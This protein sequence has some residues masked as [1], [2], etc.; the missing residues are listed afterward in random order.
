MLPLCATKECK[1]MYTRS[2]WTCSDYT[3]WYEK[4]KNHCVYIVVRHNWHRKL[5]EVVRWLVAQNELIAKW[6]NRNK[7]SNQRD[8]F[9][10]SFSTSCCGLHVAFVVR[11]TVAFAYVQFT[12]D[13]TSQ[14]PRSRIA[15]SENKST[16]VRTYLFNLNGC[17]DIRPEII[18]SAL[19]HASM[20]NW[21]F[22][23]ENSCDNKQTTKNSHGPRDEMHASN[24]SRN[25]KTE[26]NVVENV[27]SQWIGCQRSSDDPRGKSI[28]PTTIF[29]RCA[30]QTQ[31]DEI[32][33]IH[34]QH[35]LHQHS[36]HPIMSLMI[37]DNFFSLLENMLLL[38]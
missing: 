29:I 27:H 35:T 17:W 37:A 20:A 24:A 1:Y 38:F 36:A 34:T 25:R 9:F 26:Q 5:E 13:Q 30:R 10:I 33:Y 11:Q 16:L 12:S 31:L 22:K 7:Q 6:S 18:A 15:R 23:I 28:A 8:N 21:Q 14:A 3:I 2:T 32:R 19:T 4:Q